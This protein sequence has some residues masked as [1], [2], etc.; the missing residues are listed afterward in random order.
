MERLK[1]KEETDRENRANEQATQYRVY[2]FNRKKNKLEDRRF[3]KSS[4]E[5]LESL[6][7]ESHNI[8][9]VSNVAPIE[10]CRLVA[11][12]HQRECITQSFDGHEKKLLHQLMY[13]I[14]P[15]QFLLETREEIET[16]EPIVPGSE[17]MQ[18]YIV[19][20]ETAD[21]DGPIP[22][23]AMVSGSVKEFRELLSQKL[24]MPLDTLQVAA[25]KYNGSIAT[26]L[27]VD[28]LTLATEEVKNKSKVFVTTIPN[29]PGNEKLNK[30]F[31]KIVERSEHVITLYFFLPNTDR[32]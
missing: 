7:E 19:D 32:G 11:Y 26:H 5:T 9:H 16:F 22:I 18:V 29:A 15:L 13:N 2:Y 30:K 27:S 3:Y 4:D 10:R 23:R 12:N 31:I 28:E 8:F 6:L 17:L 14:E 20:M 24:D 25:L 21:I 1:K